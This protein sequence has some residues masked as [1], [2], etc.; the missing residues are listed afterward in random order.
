MPDPLAI[1]APV[2]M[3]RMLEETLTPK[4]PGAQP[5]APVFARPA[6]VLWTDKQQDFAAVRL[7]KAAHRLLAALR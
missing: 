3:T 4:L 5:P 6:G 7:A 2:L 1:P